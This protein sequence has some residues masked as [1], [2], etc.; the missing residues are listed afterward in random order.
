MREQRSS[1]R[2]LAS[3]MIAAIALAGCTVGPDYHR[4]LIST[5]AAYA[6]A[7]G[8]PGG[9]VLDSEADLATWWTRLHDPILNDLVKRALAGN[10]DLEAAAS[11]VRQ[12]RQSE[13]IIAAAE[14]PSVCLLYTS[15]CV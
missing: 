9:A 3:S 15:R 14:L 5:P 4:P 2:P 10:P 8:L 1:L 7:A 6:E 12:A 13:R 11:R